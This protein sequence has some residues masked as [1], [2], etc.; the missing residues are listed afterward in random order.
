MMTRSYPRR[1]DRQ[2]TR[3]AIDGQWVRERP[4]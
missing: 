3:S 4:G 2:D 1:G